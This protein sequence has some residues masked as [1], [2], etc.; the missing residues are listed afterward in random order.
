[1]CVARSFQ[2]WLRALCRFN[3]RT[4]GHSVHRR[5]QQV[6]QACTFKILQAGNL[7]RW[8]SR[9]HG[10]RIDITRAG[11]DAALR[12]LW[13]S[14]LAWC[15]THRICVPKRNPWTLDKMQRF[16]PPSLPSWVKAV[17]VKYQFMF[18][19]Y[20]APEI[21]NQHRDEQQIMAATAWGLA[22]AQHTLDTAK[23]ALWLTDQ[24]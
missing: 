14:F 10:V 18:I 17:H 8:A 2:T 3:S 24:A 7:Q 4:G 19:A 23:S 21:L 20:A 16:T 15:S 12:W 5:I 6:T 9:N 13:L 22:H 1:M 11:Q